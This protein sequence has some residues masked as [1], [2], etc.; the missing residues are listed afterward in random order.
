MDLDYY[1]GEALPDDRTADYWEGSYVLNSFDAP[2]KDNTEK[3]A[4][5]LSNSILDQMPITEDPRETPKHVLMKNAKMIE[6]KPNRVARRKV[7]KLV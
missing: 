6:I 7:H 5:D 1:D 3:V 2:P 4:T